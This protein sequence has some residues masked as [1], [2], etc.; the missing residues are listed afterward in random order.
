MTADKTERTNKPTMITK[1]QFLLFVSSELPEMKPAKI[2]RN[3][4]IKTRNQ[5]SEMSVSLTSQIFPST[6]Q[7]DDAFS[8]KRNWVEPR[9]IF[10]ARI[11]KKKE[12][13]QNPTPGMLISTIFPA[14]SRQP[15][16]FDDA[17]SWTLASR[18]WTHKPF[19]RWG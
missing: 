3:G 17:F 6:K 1:I 5:D 14:F 16:R 15:N 2:E 11:K 7:I 8:W 12:K 18:R 10:L 9:N 19:S 4:K 13:N